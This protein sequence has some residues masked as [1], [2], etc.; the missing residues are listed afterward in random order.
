VRHETAQRLLE[1]ERVTLEALTTSHRRRLVDT[2]VDVDELEREQLLTIIRLAE[3]RA[4]DVE[5]ALEKL[6]GGSYGTC[7]TCGECI[8]DE[9]LLAKP[10]ARFC[11]EHERDWEFGR[12]GFR[13]PAVSAPPDDAG[14]PGWRELA[15]MPE[16]DDDTFDAPAPELSSEEHAIHEETTGHWL[17]SDVVEAAEAIAEGPFDA[18]RILA[19]SEELESDEDLEFVVEEERRFA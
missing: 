19:I 11:E 7:E 18:E 14:E 10:D 6:A 16:D 13:A 9:R 15:T 17:D 5:H 4:G 8:P 1:E 3:E 2:A 12:L